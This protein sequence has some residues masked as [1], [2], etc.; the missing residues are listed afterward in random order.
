MNCEVNL[1]LRQDNEVSQPFLLQ[2]QT[3][4]R[5]PHSKQL[6]VTVVWLLVNSIIMLVLS[7]S[8]HAGT[9]QHIL[10]CLM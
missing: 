1:I 10:R 5:V 8:L 6:V 3:H 2:N 4:L 7:M 9:P